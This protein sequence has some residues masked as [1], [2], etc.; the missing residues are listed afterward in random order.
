MDLLGR[1]ETEAIA[2]VVAWR[3]INVACGL[4]HMIMDDTDCAAVICHSYDNDATD[5]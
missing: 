2:P 4:M 3:Q 5:G 1:K